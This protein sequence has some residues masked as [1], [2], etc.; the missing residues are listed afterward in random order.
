MSS[1]NISK[2]LVKEKTNK[3][4][5]H[6]KKCQIYTSHMINT[7]SNFIIV[8]LTTFCKIVAASSEY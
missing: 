6:T 1:Q 5:G 3:I 4:F 2:I 8:H 7:F